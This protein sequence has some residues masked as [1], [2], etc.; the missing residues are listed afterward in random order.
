[1]RLL[2]F[3]REGGHRGDRP[4]PNH[5]CVGEETDSLFVLCGKEV[6][7]KRL[8][9]IFMAWIR[10]HDNSLTENPHLDNSVVFWRFD[11]VWFVECHE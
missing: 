3:C 7:Y 10:E 8:L 9:V 11:D 5:R 1:M 2:Q 4:A 6:D